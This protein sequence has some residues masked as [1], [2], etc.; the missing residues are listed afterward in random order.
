MRVDRLQVLEP[1]P[2]AHGLEERE[3]QDC[4]RAEPKVGG[5]PAVE[6]RNGALVPQQAEEHGCEAVGRV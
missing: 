2:S 4:M 1:K 6:E 3:G 5:E